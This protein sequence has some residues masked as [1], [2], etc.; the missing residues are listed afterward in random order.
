MNEN[1]D[2]SYY[3]TPLPLERQVE[4]YGSIN[5]EQPIEPVNT[6]QPIEPVNTEQPIE[7]VE[8]YDERSSMNKPSRIKRKTN[9]KKQ[10]DN[11]KI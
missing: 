3:T 9:K 11:D 7:P 5:T 8:Y 1:P 10:S 2:S 4:P 6:E